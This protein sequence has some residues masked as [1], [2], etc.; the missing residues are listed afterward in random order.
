[1]SVHSKATALNIG[2]FDPSR[3]FTEFTVSR[4]L[5]VHDSTG[6]DTNDREFTPGL[7]DSTVSASAFFQGSATAVESDFEEGLSGDDSDRLYLI[8][9][10][11]WAIGSRAWIGNALRT[12]F[13]VS[14]PVADLVSASL[15]MQGQ[16]DTRA[17]RIQHS[18][19]TAITAS[20]NGPSLDG[21]VATDGGVIQVHVTA[22]TLDDTLTLILQ[23]STDG[24]VW[25][26]Y[27]EF[28]P[29]P[30][31]GVE[32]MRFASTNTLNRY[33]RLIAETTGEGAATVAAALARNI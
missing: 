20:V 11:G 31:D 29:I 22:N 17:G 13:E 16:P 3:Y 18:P 26:D 23:H 9:W 19:R 25:V 28:D 21:T 5:E 30:A 24:S 10:A 8:A 6:F 32:A 14:S 2:T 15:S 1:M 7:N 27:H 4:M 33:T 12:G